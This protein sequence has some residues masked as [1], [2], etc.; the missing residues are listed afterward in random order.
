MIAFCRLMCLK[1]QSVR[2]KCRIMKRLMNFTSQPLKSKFW[3]F[4]VFPLGYQSPTLWGCVLKKSWHGDLPPI[5]KKTPESF[6]QKHYVLF[7]IETT[8]SFIRKGKRSWPKL[9]RDHSIRGAVNSEQKDL[10]YQSSWLLSSGKKPLLIIMSYKS[11]RNPISL[12]FFLYLLLLRMFPAMPSIATVVLLT[13]F[14][15]LWM[16]WHR[17]QSLIK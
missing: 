1:T 11:L 15:W 13:L 7:Y 8:K 10:F 16:P 2:G 3:S 17:H 4:F 5:L 6:P 9:G 12:N 14:H